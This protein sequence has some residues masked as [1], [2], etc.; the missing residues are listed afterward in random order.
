M[1]G[2]KTKVSCRRLLL[3]DNSKD[4]VTGPDIVEEQPRLIGAVQER[5]GQEEVEV[6]FGEQPLIFL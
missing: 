6:A 5:G 3:K 1:D 2:N 4:G